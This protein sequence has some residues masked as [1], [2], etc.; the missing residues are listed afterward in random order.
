MSF[1][2]E[3]FL[4]QQS[5]AKRAFVDE[6]KEDNFF[7]RTPASRASLE[8][9]E[10]DDSSFVRSPPSSPHAATMEGMQTFF[11]KTPASRASLEEDDDDDSSFVGSPPS[12]PRAATMEDVETSP[13]LEI[14]DL[15]NQWFALSLGNPAPWRG[16]PL[17]YCATR[18]GE[19]KKNGMWIRL[20]VRYGLQSPHY[21]LESFD[22]TETTTLPSASASDGR[23][24]LDFLSSIGALDDIHRTRNWLNCFGLPIKDVEQASYCAHQ[25]EQ[26]DACLAIAEDPK[27]VLGKHSKLLWLPPS[28]KATGVAKRRKLN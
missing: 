3:G 25:R 24:A 1:S 19:K 22:G 15:G 14:H 23:C 28:P 20:T 18:H 10:E 5:P 13:R 9:E 4:H 16:I 6:E 7:P 8:K 27:T 2:E 26:E 21:V 12:S 17:G 11:P